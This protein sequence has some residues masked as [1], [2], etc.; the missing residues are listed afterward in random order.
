MVN[1]NVLATANTL[2]IILDEVLVPLGPLRASYRDLPEEYRMQLDR[3]AEA[4][5]VSRQKY[6]RVAQA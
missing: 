6:W 2:E 1:S 5:K 3:L 4:R